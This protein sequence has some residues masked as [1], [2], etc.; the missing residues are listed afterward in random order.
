MKTL[1]G[2]VSLFDTAVAYARHS[3]PETSHEA[4]KSVK[5]ITALQERII[6]LLERYGPLTDHELIESFRSAYPLFKATD[7]SIR[8]RRAE[9]RDEG[10]VFFSGLFGKTPSGRESRKWMA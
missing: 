2:H 10:R 6:L 5:D 8:S 7:Q 1:P 9:L 4:A 3:D